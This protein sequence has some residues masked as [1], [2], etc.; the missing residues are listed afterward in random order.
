MFF[1]MV[2]KWKELNVHILFS[3][4]SI[5]FSANTASYEV[6]ISCNV[7]EAINFH[8]RTHSNVLVLEIVSVVLSSGGQPGFRTF[9]RNIIRKSL[10]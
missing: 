4:I 2:D 10:F 9:Y 1:K 5:I 7:N 3:R 8:N 6:P